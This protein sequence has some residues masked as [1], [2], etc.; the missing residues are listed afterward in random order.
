MPGTRPMAIMIAAATASARGE[1]NIC[2][3]T[4]APMSS[5][6]DTRVTM[7]AAAVDSSSDGICA[8]RPSPMVSR[9]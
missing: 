5:E 2:R 3:L 4:W 7:I 6:V 9:V 1:A 8:T